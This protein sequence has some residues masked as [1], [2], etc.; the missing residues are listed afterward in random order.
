MNTTPQPEVAAVLMET[1][2]AMHLRGY[3]PY[4]RGLTNADGTI[5]RCF[6]GHMPS[7]HVR[8]FVNA[9]G[10]LG[11]LLRTAVLFVPQAYCVDYPEDPFASENLSRFAWNTERAVAFLAYAAHLAAGLTPA[12]AA[13]L[14]VSGVP[15]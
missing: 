7:C 10:L 1:A 6:I 14:A 11:D 2:G 5:S 13:Q 12:E 15:A 3:S 4:L 8:G 9:H